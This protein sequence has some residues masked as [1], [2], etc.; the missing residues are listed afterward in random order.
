MVDQNQ[1]DRV[2]RREAAAWHPPRIYM[3]ASSTRALLEV[4]FEGIPRT[5]SVGEGETNKPKQ[6]QAQ[7]THKTAYPL[8]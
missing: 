2:V 1:S 7:L 3:D 6:R 5:N 8:L 4:I